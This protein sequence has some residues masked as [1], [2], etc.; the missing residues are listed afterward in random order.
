ML[1]GFPTNSCKKSKPNFDQNSNQNHTENRIKTQPKVGSKMHR[2][3]IQKCTEIGSKMAPG[4]DTAGR[5]RDGHVFVVMF[6][7]FWKRILI[8]VEPERKIAK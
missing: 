6:F 8:R 7:R 5:A 2:K 3:P 4:P 1:K